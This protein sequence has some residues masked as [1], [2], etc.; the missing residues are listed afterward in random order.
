MTARVGKR[1]VVDDNWAMAFKGLHHVQLAMPSG[2]DEQAVEFYQGVLGIPQVEKPLHLQKRGGCWFE[3]DQTRIHLGVDAEFRPAVKAHPAILVD[4]LSALR[5]ALEAAHVQ[6]HVD[7]PLPEHDRF[8][9]SDPF[10]NRIEFLQKSVRASSTLRRPWAIATAVAGA[11][12]LAVYVTLIVAQGG[13]SFF[14]VLPWALLM[15][16]ATIGALASAHIEE[17]RIAR[18][19]TIAVAVLFALLGY[20]SISTIGVGFLLAAVLATV[21]TVRS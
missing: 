5:S 13:D 16:V 19:A 14:E 9:I 4:D 18:N 2:G 1:L 6:I 10:G 7:Q 20:V 11:S 12:M 8:Y 21:A 3:I 15:V 17:R